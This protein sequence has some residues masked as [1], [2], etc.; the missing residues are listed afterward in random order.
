MNDYQRQFKEH[1][2][3]PFGGSTLKVNDHAAIPEDHCAYMDAG[4]YN[5]LRSVMCRLYEGT[6]L[7]YDETR[8]LA[9]LMDALFGNVIVGPVAGEVATD[10]VA[11]EVERLREA[12]AEAVSVLRA[13]YDDKPYA[14]SEEDL[15]E[16]AMP[17]KEVE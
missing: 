12:L 15:D 16:W 2:F 5:R 7:C 13:V 1:V 6:G 14:I 10:A 8:D 17:V 9:N 3:F 4:T 11:G